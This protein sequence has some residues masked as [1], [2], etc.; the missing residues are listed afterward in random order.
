[1]DGALVGA[2]SLWLGQM[3]LPQYHGKFNIPVLNIMHYIYLI[4]NI[5]FLT[6]PVHKTEYSR[7]FFYDSLF[8][9]PNFFFF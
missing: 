2:G 7:I 9:I 8:S 6:I 3:W 4:F 5:Y 1:V